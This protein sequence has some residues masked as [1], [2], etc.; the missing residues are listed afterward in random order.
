MPIQIT[1]RHGELD[2]GVKQRLDKKLAKV[3][4][5]Y[6]DIENIH[7]IIDTE[8]FRQIVEIVVQVKNQ[9]RVEAK[10]TSDDMIKSLDAAIDKI[11]K[12]LRKHR[13]KIIDNKQKAEK[14]SKS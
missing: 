3:I 7:V 5:E 4:D 11:D 8:K 12:Q 10:Q 1:R 9:L 6:S 14:L 13:E 2:N